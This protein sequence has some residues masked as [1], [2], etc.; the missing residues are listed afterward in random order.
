MK[1]VATSAQ[2]KIVPTANQTTY[3]LESGASD[4]QLKIP[5]R[6]VNAADYGFDP[7]ASAAVNVAVWN[8][9]PS[10]CE[11]RICIAGI[12]EINSTLYLRSNTTY[13]FCEGITIKKTGASFNQVFANDAYA[14]GLRNENISLYGNGLIIDVNGKETDGGAVI[15]YMKGHISIYDVYNFIIDGVFCNTLGTNQYFFEISKSDTF[16]ISNF[17]I[18]GNKDGVD[19]VGE[20]SN[21]IIRSVTTKTADDGIFIGGSGY[22]NNLPFLGNMHNIS[23][24]DCVD[25]DK[26]DQGGSAI[27]L[28]VFS[29]AQWNLGNTYQPGEVCVNNGR[30]YIKSNAIVMIAVDPPVHTSGIVTGADGIS[31]RF[32]KNGTQTETNITNINIKNCV[33]NSH[34]L[35]I[36]FEIP[37]ADGNWI[38]WTP[39][40]YGNAFVDN[41]TID[42]I[43]FTNNIPNTNRFYI[44]GYV[45]NLTI[46]NTTF[47][48]Y[49]DTYFLHF[50]RTFVI[51]MLDNLI[52]D[53]CNLT[54]NAGGLF[55][56]FGN[57]TQV[58]TKSLLI[59]DS[60]II[61]SDGAT[62]AGLITIFSGATE[63]NN[64]ALLNTEFEDVERLILFNVANGSCNIDA[65]DCSFKFMRYLIPV[66]VSNTFLNYVSTGCYYEEKA[67]YT[68]Y[69]FYNNQATSTFLIN[70]SSSSG[71]VTASRVRNGALVNVIACDL[72]YV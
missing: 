33:S 55:S 44:S 24:I 28:P 48:R 22:Y 36:R 8:S 9:L 4:I 54:F 67:A 46:K 21:G 32:L 60:H 19:L 63:W 58:F 70:L 10:N 35:Y 66:T 25:E 1:I 40:T 51:P 30:I 39:G 43:T 57:I 69:L 3:E 13:R 20:C 50:N 41:V 5:R 59:K 11:V 62:S 68:Q 26:A 53:N 47:I 31:W 12:Y 23:I 18:E 7:D 45:K 52:I 17:Y 15:P 14:I 72:P 6:I 64:I 34:R 42:N 37:V 56:T 2:R 61:G 16:E 27:R 38:G 71:S 65:E 29:W 49:A